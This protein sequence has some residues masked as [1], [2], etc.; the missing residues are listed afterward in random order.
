MKLA[1]SSLRW[2]AASFSLELSF[3]ITGRA[4]GLFG[5]SGAGKTSLIELVAGLRR[6]DSGSIALDDRMLSDATSRLHLA[7]ET[8][9]VGYVPQDGAL[10]PHLDVRDNLNFGLRSRRR[11]GGGAA[12][13][14]IGATPHPLEAIA[15]RLDITALLGR[16]ITHL[17][18][19]ERQRVALARALLA[20]PR[21]LLL[22]EPFSSLDADHKAAVFPFLQ[23]VRDEFGV[24]LVYVSHTPGDFFALCDQVIVLSEGR[25]VTRGAPSE[26]FSTRST[27]G[28]ELK[29]KR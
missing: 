16:R 25:C 13:S 24:P 6:P 15:E 23:R 4:I 7:P 28:Y 22:D 26:V 29:A 20:S 14:S 27:P 19:G 10:F 3:V 12:G 8:R 18:G 11:H 21:L 9:C 2:H 5:N 1:L 17:S